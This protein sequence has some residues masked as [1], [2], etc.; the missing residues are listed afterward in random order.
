MGLLIEGARLVDPDIDICGDILFGEN[1]EEIAR[2]IPRSGHNVVDGSGMV[3]MPAF[4]DL[5]AHFRDPGF[6]E[7]EDLESGAR[8][9]LAGGYT[10]V[11]LMANTNPICDNADVYGYVMEKAETLDLIHIE[12]VVA[13]TKGFDG[14]TTEHWDELPQRVRFLSDDGNGI[15]S[16]ELM[17]RVMRKATERGLGLMLHEEDS[18][19]SKIDYRLA[20]DV[21]TLRDVYLAEHSGCRVHFSH[22]STEA[23]IEA[24]RRAKRRVSNITCEVTPHH[25]SMADSDYRVNPPIRTR[26]DAAALIDAILDGTVDAIATDHAPHSDEDKRRGAPGMIGL[27]TAFSTCYEVLVQSGIISL[28]RLVELMSSNPARILGLNKGYLKKGMDADAVL[29]DLEAKRVVTGESLHSKSS[30]TPLLGREL[31]AAIVG[32]IRAGKLLYRNEGRL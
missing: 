14:A 2:K 8:A 1:I 19:L 22:V 9:A 32:T 18:G 3:L 23:S 24:V 25:I 27:E 21:M 11:N 16:S 28:Q 5:H 26:R 29:V 20:E 10:A 12:Q 7:K 15:Q 13:V 6:P 4:I 30:N 31:P 17:Y